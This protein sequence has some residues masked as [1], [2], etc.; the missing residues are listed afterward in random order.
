MIARYD[1]IAAFTRLDP[2]V[3]SLWKELDQQW[4]DD[5][6]E[7]ERLRDGI[8]ALLASHGIHRADVTIVAS[9]PISSN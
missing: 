9:P 7:A 4:S 8:A 6:D 3:A 5:P 1:M 2:G